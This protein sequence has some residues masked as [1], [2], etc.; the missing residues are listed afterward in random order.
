MFAIMPY[1][2][3]F[4]FQYHVKGARE[5]GIRVEDIYDQK[6]FREP[7]IWWHIYAQNFHPNT[8]HERVR[9]IH[10]FRRPSDLFKGFYVPDWAKSHKHEGWDVDQ[11]SREAWENAYKEFKSEWTPCGAIP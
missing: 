9:N 2:S 6:F 5:A 10:F 1:L 3:K 4:T 7:M 8:L 11:Y